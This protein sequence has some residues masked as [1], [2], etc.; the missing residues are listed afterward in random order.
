MSDLQKLRNEID[1]VDREI[2]SLITQRLTIVKKIAEQKEQTNGKVFNPQREKDVLTKVSSYAGPELSSGIMALYR[3]LMRQSRQYQYG[4][5]TQNGASDEI[6][7]KIDEAAGIYPILDVCAYGGLPGSYSHIAAEH[8]YPS[9]KLISVKSFEDV[10][11]SVKNGEAQLGIVPLENT[12]EGTVNEVYDLLLKYN[13]YIIKSSLLP[14]K[15][16]LAAVNGAEGVKIREVHSHPQ[17]LAQCAD[18][19]KQN[20]LKPVPH[21][22]TAVA[23][24]FVANSGRQDIAAISSVQAAKQFKLNILETDINNTDKNTTRFISVCDKLY[25]DNNANKISLSFTLNHESGTLA[26][27]LSVFADYGLN[28]E[29]IQSRPITDKPWEY[30]FYLDFLGKV[31]D[32]NVKA[33]MYQLNQ[34][35]PELRFLGAYWE[36]NI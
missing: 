7:N 14:V 32:N 23:A 33:L 1:R 31:S 34:E 25:I 10:F 36:Q 35:L 26:S 24:Q 6:L 2:I 13:F 21:I 30:M 5:M 22:N 17:A 19:I 16:C 28:L 12:T 15:H 29:K 20:K 8:M 11:L 3:V 4:L 18:F 27:T 9:A